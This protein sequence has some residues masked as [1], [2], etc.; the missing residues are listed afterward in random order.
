MQFALSIRAPCCLL[1]VWRLE[2]IPAATMK[3]IHCSVP[4]THF[5]DLQHGSEYAALKVA[6]CW[7]MWATSTAASYEFQPRQVS[8]RPPPFFFLSFLLSVPLISFCLMATLVIWAEFHWY[9]WAENLKLVDETVL[10][11]LLSRACRYLV[12]IKV[13]DWNTLKITYHLSDMKICKYT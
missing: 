7:G 8:C 10:K 3:M 5:K 9:S 4:N 1:S 12:G 11:C 13:E 2:W 6:K